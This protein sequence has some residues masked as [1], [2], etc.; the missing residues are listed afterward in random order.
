MSEAVVEEINVVDDLALEEPVELFGVDPMRALDL[1]VRAR[2]GR[3][4]V[5]VTDAFIEQVPVEG[6]A[7]LDP[8]Y[9]FGPSRP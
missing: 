9:P 5:D 4:D 7:E 1:P 3:L 2:G 6:L 8:V